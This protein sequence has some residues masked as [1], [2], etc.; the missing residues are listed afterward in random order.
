VLDWVSSSL[1][2]LKAFPRD[3]QRALGYA[4]YAAEL[5]EK[6]STAKPLKGFSGAGVLE[7]VEDHDGETYRAIYTVK[8]KEVVYVL[9]SFQKK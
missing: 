9:H 7:I 1:R 4:L 6:H 5:G 8:F 2:D 3:V